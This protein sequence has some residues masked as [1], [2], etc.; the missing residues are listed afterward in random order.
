M[1]KLKSPV[2][3]GIILIFLWLI[4]IGAAYAIVGYPFSTIGVI[5][6]LTIMVITLVFFIDWNNEKI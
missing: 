3:A 5:V 1:A 4:E 2:M 6:L